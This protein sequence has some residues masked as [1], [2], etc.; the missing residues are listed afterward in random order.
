MHFIRKYSTDAEKK[1]RKCEKGKLQIYLTHE[2]DTKILTK[3]KK[4]KSCSAYK[5]QNQ[6]LMI[7]LGSI[8]GIQRW[9][10]MKKCCNRSYCKIK[11]EK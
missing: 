11:R 2:E 3:Y 9:M 1:Q 6:Y 8:P 7:K 4:T 10:T 5:R